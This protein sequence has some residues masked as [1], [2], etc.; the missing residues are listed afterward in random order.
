MKKQLNT[1]S[2]FLSLLLVGCW[3]NQLQAQ[4]TEDVIHLKNG[5]II[6]GELLEY[7]P[8]GQLKIKILGGSILVYESSEVVKIKTEQIVRETTDPKVSQENNLYH[9]RKGFY[10]NFSTGLSM[11][12]INGL[13]LIPF[14]HLS[15]GSQINDYFAIGGGTGFIFSF[16]WNTAYTPLYVNFRTYL[17]RGSGA[18]F[19]ETNVGIHF[20]HYNPFGGGGFEAGGG[21][22]GRPSI[23]IRMPSTKRT[24]TSMDLGVEVLGSYGDWL[25]YPNV[26]L[27]VLF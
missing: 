15:F 4:Q 17:N 9:D 26:R 24:H 23:G 1:W 20:A 16:R 19:I 3:S 6:R 18:V 10:G 25:L 11:L 8:D 21:F 2:L 5:S 27:S 22:Y 13:D 7:E 14:I 12:V